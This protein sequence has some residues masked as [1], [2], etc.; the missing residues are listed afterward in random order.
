MTVVLDFVP[1]SGTGKIKEEIFMNKVILLGRIVNDPEVHFRKG[2]I[3]SRSQIPS[4]SQPE[5]P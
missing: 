5:I 3:R 1:K 2:E 4:G